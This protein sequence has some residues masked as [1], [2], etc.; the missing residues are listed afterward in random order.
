MPGIPGDPAWPTAA[1]WLRGDYGEQPA[2]APH[3]GVIGVPLSQSSAPPAA[4]HMTPA[5]FRQHLER[6]ACFGAGVGIT[7]PRSV[8]LSE[9]VR[10]SDLG[11]LEIGHLHNVPAQEK[12]KTEFT[13]LA[14]RGVP[15]LLFCIGGDDAVMRPVLTG[16]HEDPGRI[17]LMMLDSHHDVRL[18]YRNQGPHNGAA[19]R[20]MIEEDGL[21]GSNVV[22]IGIA[23]FG[24]SPVYRRYC[25]EHGFT[26]VEAGP[27]RREGFAACVA[28]HLDQLAERVDTIIVDIDVDVLDAGY[29][30]ASPGARPG[31][32]AP[33]ELH[34]ACN[35][36]GAHPA[37]ST[38][39]VV[40]VDK[41][42]D[43][44]GTGLDN[45][46]VCFLQAA[47]GLAVRPR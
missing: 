18:G 31:Q 1:E 16:L 39:I 17:G 9:E 40:E 19:V 42:M 29:G 6:F 12:I 46:C 15:D 8:Y 23:P 26:I 13:E 24:N 10:A 35:V 5:L 41:T 14:A 25:D 20:F 28:R 37:V 36:I 4:Q 3:I 38:L 45:A 7:D 33:W 47:C 34:E 43:L 2:S 21:L 27:A 22:Q 44:F 30:P 11:T 32:I